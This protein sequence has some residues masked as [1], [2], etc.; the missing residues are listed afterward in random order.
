[1]NFQPSRT[2]PYL[3]ISLACMSLCISQSHS[4]TYQFYLMLTLPINRLTLSGQSRFFLSSVCC[5]SV[6]LLFWGFLTM[7]FLFPSFL[8][9]SLVILAKALPCSFHLLIIPVL[10]LIIYYMFE[11][12]VVYLFES[13][14][15][16]ST[17]LTGC[18]CL[19]RPALRPGSTGQL[20]SSVV[21]SRQYHH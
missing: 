12:C 16:G 17:L 1:M 20:L 8:F 21:L 11:F 3:A 18:L 5:P 13:S 15:L 10:S 2:I 4:S 19:H 14:L 9:K 7:F 6:A